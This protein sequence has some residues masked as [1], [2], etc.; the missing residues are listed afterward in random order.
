MANAAAVDRTSWF[1][2]WPPA[3]AAIVERSIERHGGLPAWRAFGAL[4]VDCTRFSGLALAVK[5]VGHTFSFPKRF[6]IDPKAERTSFP[7]FPS[8][9]T[10]VYERGSVR[11]VDQSG[12]PHVHDR[13]R[14]RF[15]SVAARL[16][17]WSDLD[18]AYF[19]GYSQANYHGYPFSLPRLAFV[20]RRRHDRR[21][22]LTLEYPAG[23][24][25]HCRRQV[26][27]FD[28]DGLIARVDY[29]VDI[30]GRAST[31]AH[32]YEHYTEV[33]GIAFP[34]RR[35]IVARLGRLATGVNLISLDVDLA[36][37]SGEPGDTILQRTV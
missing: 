15:G 8:G 17:R 6:V 32:F 23:V 35:R 25:A 24:D 28:E 30:V 10:T 31:S 26:F 27:H 20:A 29:R 22:A 2:G 13:Y 4:R 9:R 14:A 34:R 21:D 11:V 5:G 19:L 3:A 12:A 36:A 1:A 37:V 33:A 7:D 18:V 16:A